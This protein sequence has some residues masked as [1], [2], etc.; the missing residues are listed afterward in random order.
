MD[1]KEKKKG[2]SVVAVLD[3]ETKEHLDYL[4]K[5]DNRKMSNMLVALINEKY[6]QYMD[7]YDQLL[8]VRGKVKWDDDLDKMRQWRDLHNDNN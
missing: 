5:R 4:C 7:G 1:I 3:T 6:R 8:A 2:H